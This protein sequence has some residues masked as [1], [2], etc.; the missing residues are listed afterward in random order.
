[1]FKTTCRR[2]N[3]FDHNAGIQNIVFRTFSK[4]VSVTLTTVTCRVWT[5]VCVSQTATWKR[6]EQVLVLIFSLTFARTSFSC[7]PLNKKALVAI[8]APFLFNLK[9]QSEVSCLISISAIYDALP[10]KTRL[11][12]SL[13][14]AAGS[15]R[16]FISSSAT[17]TNIPF[18]ALSVVYLVR[19]V[20]TF[21]TSGIR[22]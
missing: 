12:I 19:F 10:P 7:T 9:L 17:T 13:T 14:R 20:S 16:I 11:R 1:M 22:L 8:P 6:F 2:L 21:F 4:V 15:L 18:S 3:T 5:A